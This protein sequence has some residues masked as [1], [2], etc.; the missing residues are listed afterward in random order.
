MNLLLQGDSFVDNFHREEVLVV[1]TPVARGRR[2]RRRQKGRR[3]DRRT[4]F[5]GHVAAEEADDEREDGRGEDRQGEGLFGVDGH[6][7]VVG[8]RLVARS[9]VACGN[10][11]NKIFL[12]FDLKSNSILF[13]CL[14]GRV[15]KTRHPWIC[16]QCY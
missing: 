1:V 7:L 8:R 14:W 11:T 16:S 4:P 5:G 3:F 15:Y 9:K 6:G 12:H 13:F 10:K 2:R